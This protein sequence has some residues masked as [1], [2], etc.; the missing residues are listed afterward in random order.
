V[1]VQVTHIIR[2][3]RWGHNILRIKTIARLGTPD[4]G[5]GSQQPPVVPKF[6]TRPREVKFFLGNPQGKGQGSG[7]KDG[8]K[9]KKTGKTGAEPAR[10]EYI[11][12]HDFFQRSERFYCRT[13]E[14]PLANTST[15]CQKA[16]SP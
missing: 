4:D 16:L 9:G 2:K 14:P 8:M 6:G 11:T 13:L 12:V 1:H 10:D 7:G 3:N 15:N 5:H